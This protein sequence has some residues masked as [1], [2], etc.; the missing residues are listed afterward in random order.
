M[1]GFVVM[2]QDDHHQDINMIILMIILRK[3]TEKQHCLVQ[4]LG[5]FSL[6]STCDDDIEEEDDD[7]EE[8]DDDD[9]DD[10]AI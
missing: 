10:D 7:D 5:P 9:N 4:I 1:I 8:G 6:L 2:S 3:I